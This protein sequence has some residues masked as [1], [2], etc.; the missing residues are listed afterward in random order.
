MKLRWDVPQ[1]GP[2]R[3]AVDILLRRHP[4]RRH[5][6]DQA[7]GRSQGPAL[8]L[9]SRLAGGD[10]GAARLRRDAAGRG[11]DFD[12][13]RGRLPGQAAQVRQFRTDLV[14][15]LGGRGGQPRLRGAD[16]VAGRWPRHSRRC[17][18]SA[19]KQI[20]PAF[21]APAAPGAGCMAACPRRADRLRARSKRRC[22]RA[23]F[24][25][26]SGCRFQRTRCASTSAS[27]TPRFTT[28]GNLPPIDHASGNA[29]L[30]GTTFGVDLEGGVVKVP[31]GA[32]V[33]INAGAFA[34]ANT[35]SNSPVGRIELSLSGDAGPLGEIAN[36]ET[37]RGART[38]ARSN[39]PTSPA[40]PT[41]RSRSRCR[42][43]Q[44]T[45]GADVDW[46]VSINAKNLKSARRRS[47]AACSAT[48][49]STSP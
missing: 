35:V 17:A 45:T 39:R 10:S 26:A 14:E 41:P 36:S 12:Q 3:R 32:D 34:V 16:A 23:C 46:R 43:A 47:T 19:F 44:G 24:G 21:L 6:H 42:S 2:G 8:R 7:Q 22:R 31:S 28:V 33:A 29:V 5:R 18:P 40:P 38:G 48:P 9:R 1:Q 25:P 49:T 15:G 27:R 37:V 13:R 11:A 4:R 30:A 20:W